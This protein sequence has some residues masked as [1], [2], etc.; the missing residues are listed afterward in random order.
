MSTRMLKKEIVLSCSGKL[1]TEFAE[2][3]VEE[4]KDSNKLFFRTDTRDVVEIGI[5]KEYEDSEEEHTGFIILDPHKFITLIED[6]VIPGTLVK[7]KDT[8]EFEFK[9]KSMNATISK[10]VLC[11]NM[12]Q[13]NIPNINRIFTVPIPIMCKDK[14]T[15]PKKGYDTRFNSWLPHNTPNITIEDMEVET[16]KEMLKDILK[17]F[18]FKTNQDY[19]N[20]IAGIL[21]PFLRGLF[22]EFNVRTPVFFY[23]ANRER[24]GKD[25]LAGITGI[26]YEGEALEEAPISNDEKSISN[27]NDEL[28][29]KIL[30]AFINGRKR[31]HFSNNRGYIN[32]AVFE[33]IIT[34]STYSDRI[35]GKSEILTFDNEMEFSLSGNLGV[36]YTPDL[37]N[38]CRFINLFLE[39]EDANARTFEKPNLHL[40]IKNNRENLL[41][42]LFALVKNWIDNDKPKGSVK[43]ASF[44][45][46][47]EICGGIM[48][49]AGYDSPCTPD[50][51]SGLLKGDS[52]TE[53]MKELYMLCYGKYPD[54]WIKKRE[55][56]NIC[57]DNQIFGY[58]FMDISHNIKLSK[59]I[60]KFIGRVLSDIRLIVQDESVRSARQDFKFTKRVETQRQCTIFDEKT[61]EVGK[62]GNNGKVLTSQNIKDISNNNS[63]AQ[64]LEP[65]KPANPT[66]FEHILTK[67]ILLLAIT[68]VKDDDT[69]TSSFNDI[70][71]HITKENGTVTES[72]INM[73]LN[74]LKCDGIIYEHK[75]GYYKIV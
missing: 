63:I 13:Q 46:W 53:E 41:S 74:D 31:M 48:E 71:N 35:L 39:I 65:T 66:N 37:A 67:D 70:I 57:K 22:S 50:S 4:I 9:S 30:S 42:A 43:F 75:Y 15:F 55:I 12:L 8:D 20:T 10:T 19:T 29:K 45:E 38:R 6:Y 14:L 61:E 64:G 2:E 73:V 24:A 3:L 69:E 27:N 16:A 34:A 49:C 23:K 36:E 59:K 18:C 62:V 54:I 25:Y 5:I 52:E 11:S 28:R 44:P 21:T 47:A 40:Y 26:I 72:D 1:I 68:R 7:N 60:S 51:E 32:N 33:G 56:Q 58:D 17:E